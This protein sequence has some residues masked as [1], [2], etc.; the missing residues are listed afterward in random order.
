MV[1][2][3]STLRELK[4]KRAVIT[5]TP[6]RLLIYIWSRYSRKACKTQLY[7]LYKQYNQG[8]YLVILAKCGLALMLNTIICSTRNPVGFQRRQPFQTSCYK[9]KINLSWASAFFLFFFNF[10]SG[11]PRKYHSVRA[12]VIPQIRALYSELE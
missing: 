1:F 10:R 5:H 12:Y 8:I 2:D 6:Q 11:V 3:E 7:S 9:S 4:T